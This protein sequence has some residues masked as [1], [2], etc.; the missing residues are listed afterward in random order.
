MAKRLFLAALLFWAAL[1][2]HAGTLVGKVVAV[3]DGDTVT[4]LDRD[5]RQHRIRL[6]G[7]DAPEKKQPYYQA[8]RQHLA[9]LAFGRVATVEW[10]KTD[11][12]KRI[13]GNVI[14][15]GEDV[16]LLQV[17]AGYAWWYR[18]Y[19]REQSAEDRR[20]YEAAE[21]D[22]RKLR[23]G[24]WQDAAPVEPKLTRRASRGN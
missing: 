6:A 17:R 19:A 14:V 5:N 13:V 3:A 23:R 1:Q 11:R 20:R 18:D 16:G 2:V 7:I 12:Y 8:S 21:L 9:K 4:L 22:A 10:S 24:L 15:A